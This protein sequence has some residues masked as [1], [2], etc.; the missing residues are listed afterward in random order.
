[1]LLTAGETTDEKLRKYFENFG[2]VQDSYVSYDRANGR[3]RGFGFV[4]FEDEAVAN[5]VVSLQ[6]TID[7]RE[8]SLHTL[9]PHSIAADASAA[10][11]R[12]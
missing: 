1:M 9:Q 7:R 12:S 10:Q 2:N 4:V 5:R 11:R 8:V 6:H 3:P